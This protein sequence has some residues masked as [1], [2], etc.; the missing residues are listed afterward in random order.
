MSDETAEE[1]IEEFEKASLL[2]T[3]R[4]KV[5]ISKFLM[6]RGQMSA[7]LH[8][9]VTALMLAALNWLF[10]KSDPG[11]L[12]LNPSPWVLL[13][14]Y[15]GFRF[16]F[17]WG[18]GSGL[19]LVIFRVWLATFLTAE[20]ESVHFSGSEYFLFWG[21]VFMGAVGGF[22]KGVI[23]RRETQKDILLANSRASNESLKNL[24]AL[25]K[26]NEQDLSAALVSQGLSTSGLVLSLQDVIDQHTA[27]D[28]DEAFL[29]LLRDRCGVNS[30]AIYL[31][32]RS[33][34]GVRVAQL[35]SDN[36][37]P[38]LIEKTPMFDH[39]ERTGKIVTQKWFWEPFEPNA[40]GGYDD[41]FLAIVAHP[42]GK[43]F[44]DLVISRMNFEQIHWENFWKIE[45]AFRWYE[46]SLNSKMPIDFSL[47]H[48]PLH[49][50]IDETREENRHADSSLSL[51]PQSD[52]EIVVTKSVP[53][54]RKPKPILDAPGFKQRLKQCRHIEEQ[55]G[56]E[57]R[58][59]IFVPGE[60]ESPERCENFAQSLSATMPSS[61][62]LAIIPS[63][64]GRFVYG[65]LTAAATSEDAEQHATSLLA[66]LPD[67]D[68]R[69]FVLNLN[70]PAL[71]AFEN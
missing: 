37:F 10:S 52:P 53:L 54:E 58:L 65:L 5:Q 4:Q 25:L 8:F 26:H 7:L 62:D 51:A 56:L 17:L 59:V 20:G 27:S 40:T 46:N 71:S 38:D 19:V 12:K 67:L 15:L 47:T 34:R 2:A 31:S 1:L 66:E 61:D 36:A 68:L 64:G 70:D 18:T 33:G 55:M 50:A 22:A 35:G 28:R 63:E 13:P 30:A 39:A 3:L 24:V 43:D 48:R 11:W 9:F 60:G 21:A 32:A 57:N 41:Y 14:F 29:N 69:F 16:G 42:K 44:R 49:H 45:S 6:L 23:S